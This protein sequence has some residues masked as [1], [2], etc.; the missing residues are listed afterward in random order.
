MVTAHCIY[1]HK[2]LNIHQE[3]WENSVAVE[4]EDIIIPID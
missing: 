4:Y 3:F 2:P 1:L